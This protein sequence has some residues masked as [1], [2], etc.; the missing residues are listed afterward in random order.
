V[1]RHSHGK[2][3]IQKVSSEETQADIHVDMMSLFA[4]QRGLLQTRTSDV[5][6]IDEWKVTLVKMVRPT[7]VGNKQCSQSLLVTST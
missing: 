4:I 7:G 2:I 1:E 3:T 6:W 5:A